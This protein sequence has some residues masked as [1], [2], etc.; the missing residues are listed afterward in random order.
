MNGLVPYYINLPVELRGIIH[1]LYVE[2]C[3][4]DIICMLTKCRLEN[5]DNRRRSGYSCC[6]THTGYVSDCMYSEIAYK[7]LGY[8]EIKKYGGWIAG[9]DRSHSSS[10]FPR[11]IYD[12]SLNIEF[13]DA[14]F[15]VDSND[16]AAI[17]SLNKKCIGLEWYI[18]KLHQQKKI[19]ANERNI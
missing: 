18:R 11:T 4:Y 13:Y 19:A 7:S 17:E 10:L 5:C 8:S 3:K 9:Y 16:E 14:I 12:S 15:C 6:R 1:C 2:L